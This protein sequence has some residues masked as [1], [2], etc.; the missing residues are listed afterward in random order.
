MT[1]TTPPPPPLWTPAAAA[2][3][4]RPYRWR[5]VVLAVVL[6]AEVMDLMDSTIVNV[7]GPSIRRD[8]GGGASTL[9]WLSAA[10]HA[11][12]RGAADR[13]RAARRHLR[14]PAAV[15]DRL[16]R[17][18][19][20]VGG[21]RRG[22]VTGARDR[23]PRAAGRVRRAADP[24]GVRDAQGGLPRARDAEG[25]RDIR[26]GDGPVG[27]RRADPRRRADR[28]RPVGDRLATRV[29]DQRPGRPVRADR[30][31]AGAAARRLAPRRPARRPW[32]DARRT[33]TGGGH[34][35]AD[36]GPRG[37]LAGVDLRDAGCRDR[38][39]GRVRR[40]RAAAAR[41]HR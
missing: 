7:A 32:H 3:A 41:G 9:Q 1:T 14:A 15:P 25:V 40:L 36:P 10:L 28:R 31:G 16:G 5:W 23:V 21:L 26:P 34:L 22:P 12:V 38:A 13:G 18:H 17:L 20:D 11:D 35:S 4:A 37:R 30:R 2:P 39:A 19:R 24:P 33:R 8:L 29:P 27:D 6:A